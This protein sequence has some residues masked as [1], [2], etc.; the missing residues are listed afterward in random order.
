MALVHNNLG[1]LLHRQGKFREAE[2]LYRRALA[3]DEAALGPDHL[4]VA[5]DLDDLAT[6]L[7]DQD[8]FADAEP[9]LRRAL[10]IRQKRLGVNHADLIPTLENYAAI[11]RRLGRHDRA[12][13]YEGY[14][15]DLRSQKSRPKE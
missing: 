12:Q 11:L 3:I 13:V 9:L 4:T 6:L 7:T 8:R 15:R 2:P 14:V 5:K 1:A 10:E